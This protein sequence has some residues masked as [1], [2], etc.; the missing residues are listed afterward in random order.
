[1]MK[2]LLTAINWRALVLWVVVV[3]FF[4]SAAYGQYCSASGGCTGSGGTL[5]ID[6][7]QVGSINNTGTG[8]SGYADYTSLS[9]T[10]EI[11]TVTR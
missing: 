1:M 10:M 11:G 6:T 2:L 8:C 4:A 5:N 7:V 3:C 9:T